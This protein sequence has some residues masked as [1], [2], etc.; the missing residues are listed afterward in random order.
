M[1]VS[2]NFLRGL[3]ANLASWQQMTEQLTTVRLDEV[4]QEHLNIIQAVKWGMRFPQTQLEAVKLALQASYLSERT[5]LWQDWLSVLEAIIKKSVHLNDSS[6]VW[7][8][9]KRQ[10]QL[11]R[12]NKQLEAAIISHC[13][14]EKVVSCLQDPQVLADIYINL[15]DDYRLIRRYQEAERYGQQALAL[16]QENSPEGRL[17]S[18]ALLVLGLVAQACR[19]WELAEKRLREAEAMQ[20]Q[21]GDDEIHLA[22]ILNVLAITLQEQDKLDMAAEY[23]RQSLAALTS[24]ASELDKSQTLNSLGT[25]YIRLGQYALAEVTFKQADSEALRRSGDLFTQAALTQNIGTALKEQKRFDEAL[26]YLRR[27]QKLWRLLGDEL[28]LANTLSAVAELFTAQGMWQ[29]AVAYYD[30]ALQLVARLPDNVRAQEWQINY[31]RQK[32]QLLAKLAEE[33]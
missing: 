16:L 28:W 15:S 33:P 10:G 30:K 21:L 6:L 20:R 23:Y 19:Q 2:S 13:E 22:R 4:N 25:L 3:R 29:S 8:L 24:T 1:T 11:L 14:A 12:L 26:L 7:Q 32:E 17:H 9:Y 5:G 27:S 18:I 31:L